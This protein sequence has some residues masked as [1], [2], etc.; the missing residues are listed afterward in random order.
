[1]SED[2]YKY[3]PDFR[4]R[5]SFQLLLERWKNIVSNEKNEH[6]AFFS[7][8]LQK[9]S[10]AGKFSGPIDNY[11][12]LKQH[13]ELI[14][15]AILSLFPLTLSDNEATAITPPFSN[16]IV[17]TS[18]AFKKLYM[19]EHEHLLPLDPQVAEN[20][21]RARIAL[22]YKIILKK[23][24]NIE[25]AGGD[26]F[27]C[28]YPEPAQ[29]IY[30]YFELSWDWQFVD[31]SS[32]ISPKPLPANF[33]QN[34]HHVNDLA[35]FVELKKLLPLE[36]F[37][38]EGFLLLTIKNVT[39]RESANQVKEILLH[40]NIFEDSSRLQLLKEQLNYYCS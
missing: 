39:E 14:E 6:Q 26:A 16:N 11:H 37:V 31:I 3:A 9:F 24:Y 22:A 27:I 28:A 30:N 34:C 25:L 5:L 1:M 23:Y 18:G 29:N 10:D 36:K 20:M 40:Q 33:L 7:Q 8:L 12:L 21:S 2:F 32:S 13:S 38:F 35:S 17:Y 19:G 15:Q 4:S